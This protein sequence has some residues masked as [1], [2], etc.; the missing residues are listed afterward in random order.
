MT[1]RDLLVKELRAAELAIDFNVIKRVEIV[2]EIRGTGM[3]VALPE[4]DILEN[5][6]TGLYRRRDEILRAIR[7]L[8]ENVCG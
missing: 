6:M 1:D 4:L 3:A 7:G 8:P 2:S 5:E